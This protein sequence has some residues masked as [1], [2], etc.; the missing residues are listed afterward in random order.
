MR[1]AR[2]PAAPV[3]TEPCSALIVVVTERST[4]TSPAMNMPSDSWRSSATAVSSP[5][6]S[7]SVPLLAIRSRPTLSRSSSSQIRRS[8]TPR[9]RNSASNCR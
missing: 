4:A 7:R 2:N 3:V 1:A 6:A 8:G 5:V 9:S